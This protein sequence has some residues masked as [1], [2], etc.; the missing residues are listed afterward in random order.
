MVIVAVYT[1]HNWEVY[2]IMF[3]HPFGA[4]LTSTEVVE[5]EDPAG[6]SPPSHVIQLNDAWNIHVE[7]NLNGAPAAFLG[8]VNFNVSSYAEAFGAGFEGQVGA[9]QT[10]NGVL[11][12]PNHMKVE[13]DIAVPADTDPGGLTVGAYRLTTLITCDIGGVLQEM[14]GFISGPLVQIYQSV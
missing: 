13:A 9:T 5:V 2:K 11:L 12:A 1:S 10:V 7:L 4:T 14:A 6:I 8:P 3:E